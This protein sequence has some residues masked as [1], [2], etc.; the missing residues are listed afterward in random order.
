MA[1]DVPYGHLMADSFTVQVDTCEGE[2]NATTYIFKPV[3]FFFPP[4]VFDLPRVLM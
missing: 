2:K 1:A 4:L 3:T